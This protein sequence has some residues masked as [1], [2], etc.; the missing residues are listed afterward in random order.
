V[1]FATKEPDE[2]HKKD[3]MCIISKFA[4]AKI[5]FRKLA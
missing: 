2:E 3:A 5:N 4:T 1:I